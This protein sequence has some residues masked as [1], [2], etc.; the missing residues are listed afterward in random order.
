MAKNYFNRYVWLIDTIRRRGP[1]SLA[2]ISRQW[3]GSAINEDGGPLP[4]R[5]FHNHRIAIEDTFGI[6]IK[7]D[8]ALGYYIANSEDLE[9]DGVRDW[10]LES[11]SLNNL[12][13]ETKDMR[14][15][16]LFEEIPSSKKWLTVMV[17]AM[18]DGKAVEMTYK[19]FWDDREA[20]FIAHPWCLKLFRQRWY[21]LAFSELRKE[22]RV[23][24]LDERMISVTET[25]KAL[26]ISPKFNAREF[27]S[28]FFGVFVGRELKPGT[29]R[30]K[31]AAA[32]VNYFNSLP[33]H[34][35]QRRVE[36]HEDYSVF[37]YFLAPTFDLRQEILRHGTQVEVLAP[38]SLREEIAGDIREMAS[39]YN[40]P[41]GND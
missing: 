4:E 26:K 23:Y 16:I 22:P 39:L 29:I 33:L 1:I 38:Q 2:D 25:R 40:I 31:V 36:T 24:A 28:G 6:E 21:V 18:R 7:C 5:T 41:T 9:G 14:D 20:T 3:E 27:F 32:Q 15:R 8:R 35:T 11:L 30:L 34:P 13:N 17:N 10:L 19:S 37:E 12:L